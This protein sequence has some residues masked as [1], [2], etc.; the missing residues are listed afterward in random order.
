MISVLKNK[1]IILTLLALFIFLAMPTNVF[2]DELS[3]A[4]SPSKVV[5]YRIE[6]GETKQITFSVGNKS[7]FP[8]E[9]VE[10]NELYKFEIDITATLEDSDGLEIDLTNIISF[11]K[12]TLKCAPKEADKLIATISIPEN[13][14]RNAYKLYVNFTRKPVS[15]IEDL[16]TVAYS[17]VKVPVFIFVGN[18][19]EFNKLKTDYEPSKFYMD[20]GQDGKTFTERILEN[21]KKLCTINPI[22]IIDTFKDIQ[23]R[24]INNITKNKGTEN[25][26][27]VVDV[28]DS[29]IVNLSGVTTTN[30]VNQWKYVK[31]SS[32]QLS[33]P[34]ATVNFKEDKV[35]F[36]L[37][38]NDLIVVEGTSNTISLIKKQINNILK[39]IKSEPL[40]SELFN[41]IKVPIN[42]NYNIFTYSAFVEI[43]NIGEKDVHVSS[44]LS[45]LKDNS[46]LVG[47]GVLK[48]L[49]IPINKSENINIPLNIN[50]TLSSGNYH[51]KGNFLGGT[52]N[53]V[54]DYK[55]EVDTR[56][57]EKILIVTLVLYLLIIILILIF[58]KSIFKL[59]KKYKKGYVKTISI[60]E[61]TEQELSILNLSKDDKRLFRAVIPDELNV[62]NK[63]NTSSKIIDTI[64]KDFIVEL[65]KYNENNSEW[66]NIRY[67][68]AN[69]KRKKIIC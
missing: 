21:L 55:Y 13:F 5:D 40:L 22:K 31:V 67:L 32:E 58:I 45:L 41:Q 16:N 63:P 18:E 66:A 25:E 12:K 15:G 33:Q 17:T 57:S 34:I 53:K 19:D 52:V 65:I 43:K 3:F 14:E 2:A 4:V 30:K 38:N 37:K 26:I 48:T 36:I 59:I 68:V 60:R 29:L 64:S 50:S 61:L 35:E 8:E 49:T 6:P 54:S 23:Y 69:K 46:S 10:K 9:H 42:K 44:E 62:R 51:L 28:N 47:S 11:D 7:I 56:L 20:F 1:K 27:L 39:S 24:P